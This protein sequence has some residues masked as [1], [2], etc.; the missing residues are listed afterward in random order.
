M[1]KTTKMVKL[2]IHSVVARS[3]LA[4]GFKGVFTAGVLKAAAY[5][6]RK[7]GKGLAGAKGGGTGGSGV[8]R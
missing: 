8:I 1:K 7:V 6:M 4:Q 5:A 2:A 3:S